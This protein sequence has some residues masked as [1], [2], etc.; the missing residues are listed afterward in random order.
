VETDPQ[1]MAALMLGLKGAVVLDTGEDDSGLWIEIELEGQDV[2]CPACGLAATI[3]GSTSVERRG[4]PV[5]GRP[6]VLSWR[7]RRWCCSDPACGREWLEEVPA[8]AGRDGGQ[9]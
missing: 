4:L 3:T 5:F 1:K 8:S 7:L 9:P 2:S 6:S